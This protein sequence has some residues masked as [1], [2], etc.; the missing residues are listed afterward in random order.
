MLKDTM[1]GEIG[2]IDGDLEIFDHVAAANRTKSKVSGSWYKVKSQF[3][4]S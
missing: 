1:D 2:K 3:H 4:F